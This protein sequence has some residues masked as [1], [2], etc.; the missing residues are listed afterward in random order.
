ML[1]NAGRHVTRDLNPKIIS[2][3]CLA[4]KFA[5]GPPNYRD[6]HLSALRTL[7]TFIFAKEYAHTCFFG[8]RHC[9]ESPSDLRKPLSAPPGSF[10]GVLQGLP[11][12][13]SQALAQGQ[14]NSRGHTASKPQG[15]KAIMPQGIKAIKLQS[16]KASKTQTPGHLEST[17]PQG[18]KVTKPQSLKA[19]RLKCHKATRQ[20]FST[21]AYSIMR[22]Q[23]NAT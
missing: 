18:L 11:H 9:A 17:R 16:Q 23:C 3:L 22:I 20:T 7:Q 14:T 12:G 10:I 15:L 4:S 21:I 2:D 19:T 13:Q 8:M 5:L 6:T 1:K